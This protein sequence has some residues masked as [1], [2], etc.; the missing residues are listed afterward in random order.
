MPDEL[1][2]KSV[3][4]IYTGLCRVPGYVVILG[5]FL[6][7]AGM[8]AVGFQVGEREALL[9]LVPEGEGA[10]LGQGEIP[11]GFSQ[12]VNFALFWDV[13]DLVK[14][15]YVEQPV[16]DIALFCAGFAQLAGKGIAHMPIFPP[17]YVLEVHDH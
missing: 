6:I 3:T 2:T 9:H 17:T 15:Q 11:A 4:K 14:D 1:P 10:V 8:F 7:A 12:D 5:F 16:S 13:W